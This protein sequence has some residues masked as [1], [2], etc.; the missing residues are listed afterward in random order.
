MLE[1]LSAGL[2]LILL[3]GLRSAKRRRYPPGPR[4]LPIIGNLLDVPTDY[5]W[6]KYKEYGQQC[7]MLPRLLVFLLTSNSHYVQ[8]QI[9]FILRCLDRT[10]LW[11]IV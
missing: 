1:F 10:S 5:G 8:V 7:G 2:V 3:L 11:S 9:S 4:G 6:I